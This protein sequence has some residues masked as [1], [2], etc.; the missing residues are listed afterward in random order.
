[1]YE[2]SKL[3]CV[4]SGKGMKND[5]KGQAFM[6][7]VATPGLFT[8]EKRK[9]IQLTH[10]AMKPI[11]GNR[12]FVNH[13]NC[14]LV[15]G[16][17]PTYLDFLEYIRTTKTPNKVL[18]RLESSVKA[19]LEDSKVI[20]MMRAAA[21]LATEIELPAIYAAKKYSY[22]DL[23][24]INFYSTVFK[25][26]ELWSTED[27]AKQLFALPGSI[28]GLIYETAKEDPY[29]KLIVKPHETDAEVIAILLGCLSK[30]AVVWA[31][32][33]SGHID[34][35]TKNDFVV[36][37]GMRNRG[38]GAPS[39]NDASESKIA[40]IRCIG[41]SARNLRV[42]GKEALVM[43][44]K[45]KTMLFLQEGNLGMHSRLFDYVRRKARQDRKKAGTKD[46]VH[47]RIAEDKVKYSEPEPCT[48]R[49]AKKRATRDEAMAKNKATAGDFI[50]QL[51]EPYL[52]A[53][54][55][56][57]K[58]GGK[59]LD[60]MIAAWKLVPKITNL[61]NVEWVAI[62]PKEGTGAQNKNGKRGINK[63]DKKESIKS[64]LRSYLKATRP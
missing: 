7:W 25:C 8:E 33:A 23:Q 63:Q 49:L 3:V 20:A 44:K 28:L 39:H 48:E 17:V 18:N 43:A 56:I 60:S 35:V 4:Q 26:L 50:Q 27:G 45:N 24:D 32:H 52:N 64:V 19:G 29:M 9:W 11:E 47:R 22:I 62:F 51:V 10:K 38:T 53:E 2:L 54:G 41:Q 5:Q 6:I 40:L 14:T 42:E 46:D 37:A 31:L 13:S 58:K 16:L 57:E 55:D 12:Y 34:P 30:G 61:E 59:E 1:M 36:T 21:I 15:Y